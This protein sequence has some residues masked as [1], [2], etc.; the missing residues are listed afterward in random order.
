MPKNLEEYLRKEISVEDFKKMKF[1]GKLKCYAYDWACNI[2]WWPGLV[3][4]FAGTVIGYNL[5]ASS[6]YGGADQLNSTFVSIFIGSMVVPALR[7]GYCM[8]RDY[9][10]IKKIKK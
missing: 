7:T 8:A 6:G 9:R 10:M 4:L 1:R 2:F 5:H 3:G